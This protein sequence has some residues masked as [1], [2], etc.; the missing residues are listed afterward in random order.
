L[1]HQEFIKFI[2]KVLSEGL[3]YLPEAAGQVPGK[4]GVI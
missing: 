1:E 4:E 3:L 2:G